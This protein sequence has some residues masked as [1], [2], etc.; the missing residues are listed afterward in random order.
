MHIRLA[1]AATGVLLAV[2]P[3]STY[4][5]LSLYTSTKL[6]VLATSVHYSFL[7]HSLEP[8]QSLALNSCTPFLLAFGAFELGDRNGLG[9]RIGALEHGFISRLAF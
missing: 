3:R 6:L 8:M 1:S 4:W 7:T 5:K 9:D 2:L